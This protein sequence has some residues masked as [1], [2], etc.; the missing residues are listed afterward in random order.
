[1]SGTTTNYAFPYPSMSDSPAGGTQIQNLAT[2]V[3]TAL[4]TVD[5]R[6]DIAEATIVTHTGNISTLSDETRFRKSTTVSTSDSVTVGATETTVRSVT[7]S[8]V[9]G[10]KYAVWF[11]GSLSSDV[12]ADSNNMRIKEDNSSG[13]QLELNQIYLV[14][15]SGNGFGVYLYTEWTAPSTA[16][17]TFVLTI[18]RSNGTGTAHRLRASS[19]NPDYF[20]VERIV[21]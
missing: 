14:N 3:D 10:Q 9:S 4:D 12:S 20:A 1:M 19:T 18:Q 11:K 16:S 2:A 6:L 15:T 8:A 7:I 13:T 5:D 17:K 21:V